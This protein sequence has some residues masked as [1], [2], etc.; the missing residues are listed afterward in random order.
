MSAKEKAPRPGKGNEADDITVEKYTRKSDAFHWWPHYFAEHYL[1]TV[2]LSGD[3][4]SALMRLM[5]VY[6][7]R[8]APL[9]NNDTEL[10]RIAGQTAA[11]WR[12]SRPLVEPFFDIVDDQWRHPELDALI[13]RAADISA[14]RAEAAR[15]RKASAQ[16]VQS[17]C[18]ANAEQMQSKRRHNQNQNQIP[19]SSRSPNAPTDTDR[20]LAKVASGGAA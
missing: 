5:C 8:R 12:A 3:A 9:P 4:H 14:K 10:S 13:A 17:K 20:D 6:A 19:T 16:Q 7:M 15:A 18:S 2:H 1:S 11:Q